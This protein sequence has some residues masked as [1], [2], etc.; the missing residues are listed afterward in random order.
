MKKFQF[1]LEKLWDYKKM[2]LDKEK[3]VLAGLNS[4]KFELDQKI[5]ENLRQSDRLDREFQETLRVGTTAV[6]I[7]GFQFQIEQLQ[8]QLVTFQTEKASLK[9]QIGR[10]VTAVIGLSKEV[11]QME[12][13]HDRQMEEHRN[14]MAKAEELRIDEFISSQS[15]RKKAI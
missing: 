7:R 10:Q 6:K 9:A 2:L 5:S 3:L 8:R 11:S 4:R 1:T 12:T 15:V 13:L 14:R